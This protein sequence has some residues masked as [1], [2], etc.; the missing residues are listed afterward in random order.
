MRVRGTDLT[1]ALQAEAKRLYVHRYTGD[2]KPLWA[3]RPMPS[4]AAYPVQFAD[5][6]DW[7]ANTHFEITQKG[8]FSRRV[9]HCVSNPT[10]PH[11]PELRRVA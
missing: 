6:A 3:N 9:V 7:L 4:G 8:A 1:P 2:H 10:W 5:D 11:N